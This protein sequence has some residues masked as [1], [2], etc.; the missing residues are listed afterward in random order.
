[1]TSTQ[2]FK[3][4]LTPISGIALAIAFLLPA[5]LA[6][7]SAQA[8]GLS[9]QPTPSPSSSRWVPS[10]HPFQ[11]GQPVRHE[12]VLKGTE[13][14]TGG[15]QIDITSILR[16]EDRANK[17]QRT[18]LIYTLRDKD[19]VVRY[20]GGASGEGT[21]DEVMAGRISRGHDAVKEHPDLVE[22]RIEMV[23]SDP[24]ANRGAEEA[25][26]SYYQVPEPRKIGEKNLSKA[27]GANKDGSQMYNKDPILSSKKSKIQ[28]GLKK[29]EAFVINRF[30]FLPR[31]RRQGIEDPPRNS[32][33][34][35]EPPVEPGTSNGAASPID[36]NGPLPASLSS[37]E[38]GGAA[39]SA[40]GG[41]DF[42]T[43]ELRYLAEDSGPFADRGLRY[44]FTAVPAAGNKNLNAGRTAAVQTS[45][46][47]FVWLALSPDKFW[48]NL[49]PNEPNRIID[50]QFG[51]TDAGRILLQADLQMKKTAARLIHPDTS[52]GQQFWQQ[53]EKKNGS[54][55]CLSFRQWIVPAPATIREDGDGIYIQDAPLHVKLE[56]QS[57]Q[58]GILASCPT[59]DQ[60]T[61]AHNESVFR[62]LI[63]PR[64]EQAVNKAPEYAELR[65][66]YRSRVAAEWYRQRSTSQ[67]TTYRDL[68]NHGDISS[69][70]ARQD[71]S[72]RQVFN[73]YVNSTKKGEFRV[74]RKRREGN[75]IYTYTYIYGGVDFTTVS[76]NKLNSTDFQ[77]KWGDLP[78]VV[79]TS[80]VSP[81]ADHHGKIWLGGS[82]T[83][84]SSKSIWESI[85]FYLVPGTLVVL[86]LI[87]RTRIRKT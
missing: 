58:L 64:I 45:D 16:G 82:T 55:S 22:A 42:S 76:F 14:S 38:G 18:F 19:G 50:P 10:D 68:V 6:L 43:L 81:L 47:F 49:N 35:F 80:M 20:V 8:V 28:T 39:K 33:S 56:S 26:Y 29:I 2:Q 54:F 25:L 71:W 31:G 84:P 59:F 53:F 41:I 52:L 32:V 3:Q 62:R 61:Q 13:T 86:F 78:Q 44:A 66:V 40:P 34:P 12:R 5:Q 37:S 21:P 73:Q 27:G 23:Q 15:R 51:T 79:N 65:R 30:G 83:T 9:P 24:A 75:L 1:M 57:V 85:W 4:L 46:A 7:E 72:P 70:N 77:E 67:A 17:G 63:L 69:W 87:R 11:S 48:V 60:S 74:V 36:K